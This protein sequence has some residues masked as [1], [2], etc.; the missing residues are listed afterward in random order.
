VNWWEGSAL[1][2]SIPTLVPLATS[3]HVQPGVYAVLLGSSV[4]I[5]AG[6][7]TG[8]G[9]VQELVSHMF[10]AAFPG[11]EAAAQLAREVPKLVGRARRRKARLRAAAEELS[12]VF[13]KTRK[14][15]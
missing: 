10:A 2:K 6:R 11:D 1:A 5:G 15:R 3:V 8:W 9:V 13:P 12:G 7:P 4:S 14:P